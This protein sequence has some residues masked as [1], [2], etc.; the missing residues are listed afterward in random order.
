M[1]I[2]VLMPLD[3][4]SVYMASGL[5]KNVPH[6]IQDC[7]FAMPMFMEYLVE[8]GQSQNFFEALFFTVLAAEKLYD[9]T[10]PEEPLIIVGNM[11]KKYKFD[12]IFNF[13]DINEDLPFQDN[14]TTKVKEL[15]KDEE[16]LLNKINDMYTNEDSQLALH[17]LVATAD[18]LTAYLQTDPGIEKITE[19]Y[20]QR[21]KEI[22]EKYGNSK[23]K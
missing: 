3:E 18:F 15:V 9:A 8:T 2:L 13:Q 14:F 7:F 16:M 19:E 20:Q 23:S 6:E 21:L 10:K 11:P 12:A 4:S 5:Y 17:N 1:K 22:E